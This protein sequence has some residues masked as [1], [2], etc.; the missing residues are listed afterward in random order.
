MATI[1]PPRP[2][3]LATSPDQA[4]ESN[5][6]SSSP[7]SPTS[8]SSPSNHSPKQYAIYHHY[9][10]RTAVASH[11]TVEAAQPRTS[12]VRSIIRELSAE[13]IGTMLFMIIG[14]GV[15]CQSTLTSSPQVSSTPKGNY[16][17]VS[18][19]WGTGLALGAWVSSGI[20]G[21]HLN[22][23]V[24]LV[25]A[26]FRGFSW[27][28]VPGYMLAQV[29]GACVGAALIYANY[30]IAINIYEGGVGVRSVP[31]TASLFATFPADYMTNALCF[32]NE[33]LGTFLLVFVVLAVTDKRNGAVP[34]FIVPLALFMVLLSASASIG[35]Q[36]GFALNPARDL[37]P[38]LLCWFVGY[39][40]DV[41]NYRAQYWLYAPIMG[42]FVGGLV[43]A[44]IYDLLLYP[45]EG[46]ILYSYY[47]RL[48]KDPVE[49][50]E[51]GVSNTVG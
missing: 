35:S 5:R 19:A 26:I 43:A 2:I 41:W 47:H 29:L 36:T 14:L 45:S 18:L 23:A 33:A 6:Q 16:A 37:G 38:R 27:K 3:R 12:S 39:G 49:A 20:S 21:G 46:N 9:P 10:S 17:T 30:H 44:T 25:Q 1:P 34:G 32:Y 42:P 51:N 11:E 22:P 8:M 24:T 13:F 15:N 48:R 7:I 28:K 4:H 31:G 40:R 50:T